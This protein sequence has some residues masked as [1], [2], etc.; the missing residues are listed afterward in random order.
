MDEGFTSL[1]AFWIGGASS[2]D[3]IVEEDDDDGP[4]NRSIQKETERPRPPQNDDFEVIELISMI[5]DII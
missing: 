4:R 3:V 1:L 2:P 5:T